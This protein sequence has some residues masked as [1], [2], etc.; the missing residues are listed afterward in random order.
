MAPG[1]LAQQEP[2]PTGPVTDP[3][4]AAEPQ[5]AVP[6]AGQEPRAQTDSVEYWLGKLS[7]AVGNLEYSGLVTFEHQGMLETLQV[8]HAVR[9][10]E[11]VERVRYLSGEPRELISHG[12]GSACNRVVSP[13]GRTNQWSSIDGQGSGS[14]HFILRGGERIA[15]RD[16]VVIEARPRDQHRLGVF[17]NL[18]RETGLPLKSILVGAQGKVLERYQFVQL[19]LSPISDADLQPGSADARRI[20]NRHACESAQTRWQLGWLPDGYQRVAVRT[21]ADGDM[22]VFSDGLSVFTV[23]VQRLG[24]ELEYKGRAIRGATVAYMDRVQVE[25]TNYTVTVVGEIPDATAQR[26]AGSVAM[27]PGS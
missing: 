6:G 10:G 16:T 21:L 3:P 8:F 22:L 20:D 11:Q 12:T 7:A 4:A 18:D 5:L 2:A 26:L 14:Y 15:D 13:L 17:L 24:P 27:E 23:F 25:G 9:D 19:D 1:V